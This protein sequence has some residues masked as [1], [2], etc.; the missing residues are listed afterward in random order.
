M[1]HV[2]GFAFSVDRINVLL[3]NEAGKLTGIGS[4]LGADESALQAM[5][6]AFRAK[7]GI[8]TATNDWSWVGRIWG[9]STQVHVYSSFTDRIF[10]PNCRARS[11]N[12][13]LCICSVPTPMHMQVA[14]LPLV[15]ALIA[16][17]VD[18][19]NPCVNIDYRFKAGS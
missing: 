2:L 16:L 15:P 6:R 17:A 3:I 19:E 13:P 8:E 1:R 11:T 9:N 10:A 14:M 12:D 7:A 4:E 18:P 5:V